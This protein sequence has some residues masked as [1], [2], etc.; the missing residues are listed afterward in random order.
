[1]VKFKVGDVVDYEDINESGA[2]F[3][4]ANWKIIAVTQDGYRLEHV[5]EPGAVTTFQPFWAE[6][7]MRLSEPTPK[8][9]RTAAE[10]LKQETAREPEP[11]IGEVLRGPREA[12]EE[13]ILLRMSQLLGQNYRSPVLTAAMS[14]AYTTIDSADGRRVYVQ[15]LAASLNRNGLLPN[16]KVD[17]FQQLGY[18]FMEALD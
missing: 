11:S 12:K 3:W 13:E 6:S 9:G 4:S 7:Q 2:R 17:E 18:E 8:Y 1:M 5:G 16:D 10:I 15:D 14:S